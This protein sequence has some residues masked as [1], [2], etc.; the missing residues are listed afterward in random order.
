MTQSKD[1]RNYKH[2]SGD[3]SRTF[4]Q[5][6]RA[7]V[8]VGLLAFTLLVAMAVM[9]NWVPPTGP[10]LDSPAQASLGEPR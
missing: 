10:L 5:W 3:D 6:M 9:G 2:L 4:D 7:N 8:V 1:V